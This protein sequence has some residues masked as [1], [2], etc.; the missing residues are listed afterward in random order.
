MKRK[1]GVWIVGARGN[2]ATCAIAGTAAI[3]RGVLDRTGLVTETQVCAGLPLVD[4]P[5]L[6]F[7]GW[8]VRPGTVA[9][10]ARDFGERNGL[11]TSDVRRKI[12][13]DLRRAERE[14]RPVSYT[15]LTL[16]T[17]DLV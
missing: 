2:V 4:L 14:I 17:S 8:E 3:L 16:P 11:L 13:P 1:L 12:A 7:G 6:V 10:A 5:Q 15:H 9:D